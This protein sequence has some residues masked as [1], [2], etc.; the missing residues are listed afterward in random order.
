MIVVMVQEG[1]MED[2]RKY[3]RIEVKHLSVDISDGHEFSLGHITNISQKGICITDLYR[4]FETGDRTLTLDITMKKKLFRLL[5]KPRWHVQHGTTKT[6]GT[7]IIH[8]HS[9]WKDFV[10]KQEPLEQRDV[11]YLVQRIH[12]LRKKQQI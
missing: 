5:V 12:N 10:I 3:P 2:K 9:G 8:A 11:S 1:E 4:L 7:E 6:I